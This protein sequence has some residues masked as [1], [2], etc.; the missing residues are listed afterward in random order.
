MGFGLLED[1][2]RR[3]EV[4]AGD[5]NRVHVRST[6]VQAA[7]IAVCRG[8]VRQWL[9]HRQTIGQTKRLYLQRLECRGQHELGKVGCVPTQGATT[10][11]KTKTKPNESLSVG[12]PL[13]KPNARQT[14][15]ETRV[16]RTGGNSANGFCDRECGALQGHILSTPSTTTPPQKKRT[17]TTHRPTSVSGK[18][19]LAYAAYFAPSI[20]LDAPPMMSAAAAQ[21]RATPTGRLTSFGR[22]RGSSN[23]RNRRRKS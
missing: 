6:S 12:H 2:E 7:D 18:V 20:K 10:Q 16:L 11:N 22:S 5:A 15:S 8:C 4:D 3:R 21:H 23:R 19:R 1:F 13:H 9:K 14:Y 17:G